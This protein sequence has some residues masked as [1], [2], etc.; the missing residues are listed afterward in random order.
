MSKFAEIWLVITIVSL[1]YGFLIYTRLIEAPRQPPLEFV[2]SS[3]GAP[4]L[5]DLKRG[6]SVQTGSTEFAAYR[7]ITDPNDD[8]LLFL[9]QN[10]KIRLDETSPEKHVTLLQGRVITSFVATEREVTVQVRNL[11]ISSIHCA[12][13]HYSW[14]DEVEISNPGTGK[15]L[16]KSTGFKVEP[17]KTVRV[18]TFDG[19]I[20]FMTD[21]VPTASAAINFFTFAGWLKS[22]S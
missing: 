15:C 18:N 9:D 13:V 8:A 6:Q 7:F 19:Q 20:L 21:F 14:L 4:R 22:N 3:N 5:S 1:A 10:T 17:G 12:I 11:E 16:V 2:T